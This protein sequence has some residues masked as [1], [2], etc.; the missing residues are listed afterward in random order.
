MPPRDPIIVLE[1]MVEHAQKA[2]ALASGRTADSLAEDARPVARPSVRSRGRISSAGP[3]V[4]Q[5]APSAHS[6]AR[7]DRSPQPARQRLP[8]RG[9]CI[10]LEIVSVQL[11]PP[12]DELLRVIHGERSK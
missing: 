12:V 8:S 6:L 2:I 5:A 11:Q 1:D 10:D 3:R 9:L 4:S 7:L